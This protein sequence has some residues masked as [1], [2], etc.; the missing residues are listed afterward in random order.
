M[1]RVR[2]IHWNAEEAKVCIAVLQ[3]AGFDVEYEEFSREVLKSIKESPP[4]ALIIDLDRMP[5]QGLDVGLTVRMQKSTRGIPLVFVGGKPEKTARVRTH[6]PDATY[7]SWD[8]IQEAIERAVAR[9]VESPR[10]PESVFD[11]YA[12]TPLPKKLGIKSDSIVALFNAPPMFEDTLGSLPESVRL[13]RDMG[14]KPDVTLWFVT[15]RQ[16]LTDGIDDM[17]PLSRGGGLWILWPKKASGVLSDVSQ[18]VVREIGLRAGMVDYKIS[19]I[20]K[21]WSG[22][23]FT[24]REKEK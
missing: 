24:L 12:G 17:V 14:E 13:C 19:S 1:H 3:D 21:T 16:E 4:N 5:S 7:A 23:R 9:P 10:V 2:L 20:D 6:L 15:S 18:V 22:L 11:A 8:H